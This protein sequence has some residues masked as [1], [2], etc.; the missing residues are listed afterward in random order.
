MEEKRPWWVGMLIP[1][2]LANGAGAAYIGA[3]V[4]K[5]CGARSL[6]ALMHGDYPLHPVNIH[7]G[8]R[9]PEYRGMQFHEGIPSSLLPTWHDSRRKVA[10]CAVGLLDSESRVPKAIRDEYLPDYFDQRLDNARQLLEINSQ[11]EE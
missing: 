1:A 8:D 9:Q 10:A 6:S 2:L 7:F 5:H 11:F 4:V 3:P